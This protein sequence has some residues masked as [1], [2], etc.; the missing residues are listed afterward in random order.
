MI[1]LGNVSKAAQAGEHEGRLRGERRLFQAVLTQIDTELA[2]A[3]QR[4]DPGRVL[5]LGAEAQALR[6]FIAQAYPQQ[7]PS[8]LQRARVL[9]YRDQS[10]GDAG[11]SERCAD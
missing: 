1:Q 6:N 10:L 2:A 3:F 7:G 11:Q 5:R 8:G 4:R 9:P